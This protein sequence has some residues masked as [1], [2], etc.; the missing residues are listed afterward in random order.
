[1]RADLQRQR[2]GRQAARHA[3]AVPA[4]QAHGPARRQQGGELGHA[5]LEVVV[6]PEQ[7][8]LGGLDLALHAGPAAGA[9]LEVGHAHDVVKRHPQRQ[10]AR[11][12]VG[13]GVAAGAGRVGLLLGG[14]H[15]LQALQVELA[16]GGVLVVGGARQAERDA[17]AQRRREVGEGLFQRF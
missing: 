1:V 15:G 9:A 4:L 16:V 6:D 13:G 2:P 7:V 11:H 14:Q 3:G 17:L 12:L 8:A 5:G 10:P